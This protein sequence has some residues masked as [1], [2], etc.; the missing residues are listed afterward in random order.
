VSA[1]EIPNYHIFVRD[2]Q[3]EWQ[4]E[5]RQEAVALTVQMSIDAP[6]DFKA[7]RYKLVTC[8][9]RVVQGAKSRASSG[10]FRS[11]EALGTDIA[12]HCLDDQRVES[13]SIELEPRDSCNTGAGG[14]AIVRHRERTGEAQ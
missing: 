14:C 2:L 11:L 5:S 8:Y 10:G 9:D 13:V 3:L 1:V 4:N 7:D 6:P 12:I